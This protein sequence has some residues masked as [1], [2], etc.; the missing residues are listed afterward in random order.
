MFYLAFVKHSGFC[1][2]WF[3]FSSFIQSIYLVWMLWHLIFKTWETGFSLAIR[4]HPLSF[5]WIYCSWVW[6]QLLEV[7]EMHPSSF[8]WCHRTLVKLRRTKVPNSAELESSWSQCTLSGCNEKTK[9]SSSQIESVPCSLAYTNWWKG[10][11]GRQNTALSAMTL[12]R[13]FACF[14]FSADLTSS[15]GWWEDSQ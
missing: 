10:L 9:M 12:Y 1:L 5:V 6:L 14:L 7:W 15:T 8:T 4:C 13:L 3:F 2:I 11:H